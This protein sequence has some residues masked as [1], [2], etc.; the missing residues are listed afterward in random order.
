[1]IGS[2]RIK[3]VWTNPSVAGILAIIVL[4]CSQLLPIHKLVSTDE[5]SLG[6]GMAELHLA[7]Q[8]ICTEL[9]PGFLDF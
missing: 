3:S 5:I 8:S 9:C 1:M 2:K 7:A 4:E 6:S